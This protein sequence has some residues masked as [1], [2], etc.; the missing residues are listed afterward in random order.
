ML[1]KSWLKIIISLIPLW[2]EVALSTPLAA[3]NDAY[4][5][6]DQN[7]I[8][9]K[10]K[11]RE[12]AINGNANQKR[13]YQQ[14]IQ[15]HSQMLKDCRNRNWLKEQAIWLRIYPC[16]VMDGSIEKVLDR[17]VDL[18]YNT[19][20]VEVFFDGRVLLPQNA[21]NTVWQS[22]VNKPG[23]ENRDL[24]AETL[25]KGKERGLNMYAWLFSLNFGYSYS[26]RPDRTA[27]L[28]RNGRGQNS[29]AVVD[30]GSQVFVDPYH[31]QARQD[32][33]QL[34]QAVLQRRPD[35]VLFDYIRYPRS[36]G[37]ESVV[38]NVK[39]LWIHSEASKQALFR[40]AQN[41]QGRWLLERYVNQGFIN[42]NDLEEM[43]RLFPDELTPVW[44]GRSPIAP[45]DLA[46]LQVDIWYF[47]VAHAA[48]GVVD[49]LDYVSNQVKQRGIPAG[50]VF[51]PEGNQPVG[52]IGFDSRVQ[53][54]DSFSQSLE[55]H[56]MSYALCSGAQCI[57]QQVQRVIDSARSPSQVKPVLA[58]YWGRNDGKRPSLETQMQGIRNSNRGVTSISH[59]AYSWIEA[60]H[61]RE[62]ERC[63]MM[64]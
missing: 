15:R 6:F 56:P 4:C 46:T 31:P 55:W 29:L 8:N 19:V 23:Y 51:F 11:L 41:R 1:K 52:Q 25:Q 42:N 2:V 5:R 47:T 34:L 12:Q 45:N 26:I 37:A 14:I 7:A 27:V 18:G 22:V 48:Q 20:Y 53:P 49:F 43:R 32:Y 9:E 3:A 58:G 44:Q 28:A 16:D 62:R 50:A 40:R 36:A 35:G 63:P 64:E 57:T 24:F 60:E 33:S 39:Q 30:D 38:S 13:A 10:T 17:I 59:F 21:N 54:W 61:T